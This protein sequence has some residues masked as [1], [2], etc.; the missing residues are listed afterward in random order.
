[1]ANFLVACDKCKGSLS[2]FE[3]CSLAKSV[4]QQRFPGSQ[5]VEVAL[6]DGGEGF[7]DILT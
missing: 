7:T 5:I 2:A 3:V 6:T 1:M 4:L